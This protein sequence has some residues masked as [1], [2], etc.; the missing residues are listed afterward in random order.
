MLSL[1]NI[2][3]ITASTLTSNKF[4]EKLLNAR[5]EPQKLPCLPY[6]IAKANNNEKY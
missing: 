5:K 1:V 4:L 6:F 3:K 2:F